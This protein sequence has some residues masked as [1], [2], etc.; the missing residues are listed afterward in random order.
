MPTSL[1][2]LCTA[3]S[4]SAASA[5]S[6]VRDLVVSLPSARHPLAP[7]SRELGEVQTVAELLVRSSSNSESPDL[8]ARLVDGLRDVVQ[9]TGELVEE[10]NEALE[11]DEDED[12]GE[13]AARDRTWLETAAGK[14]AP[15]GTWMES[16]RVALNLGLDALLL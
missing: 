11:K 12:E 8:P 10:V 14:L 13:S 16:A 1:T 3:L 15:L 7:L 6:S 2:P 5:V 4:T 9:R